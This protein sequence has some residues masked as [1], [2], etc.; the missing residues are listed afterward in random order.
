MRG[1]LY[2]GVLRIRSGQVRGDQS[3]VQWHQTQ[4]NGCDDERENLNRGLSIELHVPQ[5]P[6]R[7][8]PMAIYI[9]AGTPHVAPPRH[10]PHTHC[11]YARRVASALSTHHDTIV[12]TGTTVGSSLTRGDGL[13]L[14]VLLFFL[15]TGGTATAGTGSATWSGPPDGAGNHTVCAHAWIHLL[16]YLHLNC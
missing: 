7:P 10:R 4:R 3:A 9:R 14:A 13:H 5:Q 8:P 6:V 11:T 12:V 15:L 16:Q 2:V 1:G